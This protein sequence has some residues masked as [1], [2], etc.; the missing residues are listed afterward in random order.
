MLLYKSQ[1]RIGIRSNILLRFIYANYNQRRLFSVKNDG[2]NLK[3]SRSTTEPLSNRSTNLFRSSIGKTPPPPKPISNKNNKPSRE[4]IIIKKIPKGLQKY[5]QSFLKSPISHTTSFLILHELSAII[6]L[7]SLWYI[8]YK[9]N[10]L[11]FELSNSI[12]ERGTDYIA[13]ILSTI[14]QGSTPN[15]IE[16]LNMTETSSSSSLSSFSLYKHFQWIHDLSLSEKSNLIISGAYSYTIIKLLLP[17]RAFLSLL[18]APWFTRNILNPII[19]LFNLGVKIILPKDAYL[20]F[21]KN[22]GGDSKVANEMNRELY[23]VRKRE[24]D[25]ISKGR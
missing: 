21:K 20:W 18:F 5:F 4:E 10:F 6:P 24:N 17:I 9:Y 3:P 7:F 13:S 15:D 16:S 23:R 19:R 12:I 2:D 25:Y 8:F 22:S 1:T 11:P 14:N